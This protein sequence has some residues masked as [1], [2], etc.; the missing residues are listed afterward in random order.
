MNVTAP[1]S[2]E[3]GDRGMLATGRW[4]WLRIVIWMSGLFAFAALAFFASFELPDWLHL[5]DASRYYV[6]LLVPAAALA[7]YAAAVKVGER[8]NASELALPAAP[9]NL[10][11]GGMVGFAFMALSV[12][13][14][15]ALKLDNVA[16]GHWRGWF[17]YFV[18]NSYISAVLE[19]LG[20]RAILLRLF[21]RMFGPAPGLIISAGLFALAHATHAPPLA[22]V[23]LVING[24]LLLGIV[25]MI[26]GSLWLPIGA[27]LAYDFTEWSL[28]GVGDKD[29]YLVVTP[30]PAHAAWL[31]GGSFGPDGSVFSALVAASL[32][33][34][35]VAV[36]RSRTGRS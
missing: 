1:W 35:A 9:I 25:Y 16:K 13:I 26:S 14:L 29:G 34:V 32:I 11:L 2:M 23:L 31:T 3:Y 24:G 12:V 27:H 28:F 7:L 5:P 33:A 36:G 4:S 18:F 10:V 22:V 15:W 17:S 19:E 6:G 8:R 21:A 20:F 30:S